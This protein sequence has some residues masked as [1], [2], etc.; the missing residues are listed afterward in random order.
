MTDTHRLNTHTSHIYSPCSLSLLTVTLT[1]PEVN[2][3]LNSRSSSYSVLE[4]IGEGVFGKVARCQ[5]LATKEMVA[6][7]IIKDNDSIEDIKEEVDFWTQ[8]DSYDIHYIPLL[9]VSMLHQRMFSE[10]L[11]CLFSTGFHIRA[12]QSTQ[13]RPL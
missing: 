10:L 9:R 12:H 2:N 1:T 8:F 4:F 7:K 6:V 11:S 5:N 13:S 3:I